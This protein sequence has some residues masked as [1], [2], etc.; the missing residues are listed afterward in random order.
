M[1][2]TC[3]DD[4]EETQTTSQRA[5]RSAGKNPHHWGFHC[6]PIFIKVQNLIFGFASRMTEAFWFNYFSASVN[7][8]LTNLLAIAFLIAYT[9]YVY[10]LLP[11]L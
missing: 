8:A 7:L 1:F 9:E 10:L 11:D 6:L 2:I 5:K 3:K 4:G